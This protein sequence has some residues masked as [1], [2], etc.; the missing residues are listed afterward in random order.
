M[1]KSPCITY[2]PDTACGPLSMTVSTDS[3][4][5]VVDIL[6]QLG[7]SGDC[8]SS[9]ARAISAILREASLAGC[10]LREIAAAIGNLSCHRA[11]ADHPSCLSALSAALIDAFGEPVDIPRRTMAGE[12]IQA[13]TGCGVMSLRSSDVQVEI[14]LGAESSCAHA[15]TA[16]LGSVISAALGRGVARQR[17]KDALSGTMCPSASLA[18]GTPSCI[19]AIA[20]NI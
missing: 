20:K 10:D 14:T 9:F 5:A 13:Q 11:S 4:G 15:W 17:I 8:K 19:D 3:A 18:A 7:K 1:V 6:A 12:L 2:M 16:A